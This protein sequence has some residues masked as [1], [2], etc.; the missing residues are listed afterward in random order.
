MVIQ[1]HKTRNIEKAMHVDRLDLVQNV[2]SR[3][4]SETLS[5]V[6]CTSI[7]RSD[8]LSSTMF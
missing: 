7:I 8:G 4:V 5:L 3:A 1:C 6:T 2:C